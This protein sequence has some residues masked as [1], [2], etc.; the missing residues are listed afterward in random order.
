MEGYKSGTTVTILHNSFWIPHF[1][2]SNF[3]VEWAQPVEPHNQKQDE[4]N[5]WYHTNNLSYKPQFFVF[6]ILGHYQ[7]HQNT[8]G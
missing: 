3:L 5:E 7:H 8:T 2:A 4:W 6:D 1:F